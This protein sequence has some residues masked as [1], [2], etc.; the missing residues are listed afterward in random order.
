MAEEVHSPLLQDVP[1]RE[2]PRNIYRNIAK[3]KTMPRETQA[4]LMVHPI[5]TSQITESQIVMLTSTISEDY[6]RL[7]ETVR[8]WAGKMIGGASR[9]RF[10]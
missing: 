2:V 6:G 4:T 9:L 3:S 10:H 1:N 5:F 7:W 8:L